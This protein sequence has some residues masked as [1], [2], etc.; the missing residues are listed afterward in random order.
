MVGLPPLFFETKKQ[1]SAEGTRD[2]HVFAADSIRRLRMQNGN[3]SNRPPGFCEGSQD[4]PDRKRFA[5]MKTR[6]PKRPPD[7]APMNIGATSGAE[8]RE[9][10]AAAQKRSGPRI[11]GLRVE[12]KPE[13]NMSPAGRLYMHYDYLD[14]LERSSDG[15]S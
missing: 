7:A 13:K 4:M 14:D 2:L 10:G 1:N 6:E 12:E 15:S 3:Y 11:R 5:A 9:N 8:A